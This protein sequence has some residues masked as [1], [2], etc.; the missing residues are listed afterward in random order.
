M[1][2]RPGGK[3]ARVYVGKASGNSVVLLKVL[4]LLGWRPTRA[5]SETVRDADVVWYGASF[6]VTNPLPDA[7]YCNLRATQ[8]ANRILGVPSAV[9]KG[10]MT[11]LLATAAALAPPGAPHA[12]G[13]ANDS[14]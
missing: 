6:G 4:T 7:D 2:L 8:R 1:P 3:P 9:N 13:I 5:S 11:R 10:R 12:S 14:L